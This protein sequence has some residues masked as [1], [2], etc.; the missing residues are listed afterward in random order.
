[1]ALLGAGRL[2]DFPAPTVRFDFNDCG[3]HITKSTHEPHAVRGVQQRSTDCRDD[4]KSLLDYVIRRFNLSSARLNKP[5][6]LDL[7]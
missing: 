5:Q 6:G 1:M 7:R 3:A 2:K 4:G